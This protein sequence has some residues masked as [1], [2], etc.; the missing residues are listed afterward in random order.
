MNTL[1]TRITLAIAILTL[2]AASLGFSPAGEAIA[3]KV[4]EYEGQHFARKVNEYEGQH[5][6]KKGSFDITGAEGQPIALAG[7]PSQWDK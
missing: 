1:R 5:L 7:D 2:A 4:N 6:A 3:R